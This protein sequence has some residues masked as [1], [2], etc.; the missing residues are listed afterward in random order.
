MDAERQSGNEPLRASGRGPRPLGDGR[1]V[2][3]SEVRSPRSEGQATPPSGAGNPKPEIR[4]QS[5]QRGRV[6]WAWA[7]LWESKNCRIRRWLLGRAGCTHFYMSNVFTM[8]LPSSLLAKLGHNGKGGGK[9]ARR[10][11]YGS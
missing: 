11:D 9:A 3:K 8:R 10:N 5:R 6:A 7:S 2:Q 4:G 1:G